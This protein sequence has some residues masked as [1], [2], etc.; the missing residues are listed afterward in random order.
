[1]SGFYMQGARFDTGT[2]LMSESK[3]KEL[4]S[5]MPIVTCS[6]VLSTE[7]EKNGVFS[8]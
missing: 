3:P 2:L 1:M 4:F 5:Y 8:A 6:A 7:E